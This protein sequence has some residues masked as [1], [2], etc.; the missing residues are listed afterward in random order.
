[1]AQQEEHHDYL[2]METRLLASE[3]ICLSSDGLWVSNEQI[4]EQYRLQTT[5]SIFR[6]RITSLFRIDSQSQTRVKKSLAAEWLIIFG[7]NHDGLKI[8]YVG[9]ADVPSIFK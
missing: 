2:C 4:L 6:A 8:K 9:H 1:M 7:E 5:N 3:M